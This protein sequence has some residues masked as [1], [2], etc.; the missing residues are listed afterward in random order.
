M[1]GFTYDVVAFRPTHMALDVIYTPDD[2]E[3]PPLRASIMFPPEYLDDGE[4]LSDYIIQ[5]APIEQWENHEKAS[6]LAATLDGIL[7]RLPEA[8]R[9]RSNVEDVLQRRIPKD[10]P[11]NVA[12]ATHSRI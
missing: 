12:Q 5:A 3:L 4:A 10:L 9:R 8:A 1:K 11:R 6:A 2:K 7:A